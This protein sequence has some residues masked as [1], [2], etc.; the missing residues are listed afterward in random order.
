MPPNP[1]TAACAECEKTFVRRS[2]RARFCSATCRYR[3][4]DRC[5]YEA[6]PEAE[7]ASSRRYY[8]A[9]REAVIAR[10]IAHRHKKKGMTDV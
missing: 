5:D 3:H 7:R 4:R 1:P 8:A 6:D 10:V 2:V 9:H